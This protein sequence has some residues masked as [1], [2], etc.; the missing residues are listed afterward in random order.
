LRRPSPSGRPATGP[1]LSRKAGEGLEGLLGLGEPWLGIA[2][3]EKPKD[4]ARILGRLQAGIG[5]K[6][7]RRAPQPALD[8]GNDNGR[9]LA[10]ALRSAGASL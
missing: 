9:G 4:R 3:K 5:A 8:L 6:L 10:P 7:I 1:S 2:E